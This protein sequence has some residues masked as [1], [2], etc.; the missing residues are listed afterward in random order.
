MPWLRPGGSEIERAPPGKPNHLTISAVAKLVLKNRI[1]QN[2]AQ[3]ATKIYCSRAATRF[4]VEIINLLIPLTN[5]LTQ[6]KIY[7]LIEGEYS[8]D[9]RRR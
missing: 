7:I 8:W 1:D 3:R 5:T 9:R 4:G 2:F 6:R